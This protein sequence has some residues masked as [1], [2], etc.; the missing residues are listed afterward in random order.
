MK[1]SENYFVMRCGTMFVKGVSYGPCSSL[2]SVDFTDD[3]CKAIRRDTVKSLM[4]SFK[5]LTGFTPVH[6]KV[7]L[8]DA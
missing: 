8:E 2:K 7:T 3:A 5:D 4:S 1:E 6:V